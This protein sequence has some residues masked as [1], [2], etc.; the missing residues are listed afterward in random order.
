MTN[1]DPEH[2]AHWMIDAIIDMLYGD[3]Q[4]KKKPYTEERISENEM[5]RDFDPD[6]SDDDY[7]WHRD[8]NDRNLTVLE[9]EGWQFQLDNE[10]P[11]VINIGNQIFVP[12]MVYHRLIPGKEKLRIRIIETT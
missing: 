3:G 6:I 8:L 12:K 5:I 7:V 2:L 1:Y 9:G 4:V 11:Q 10:L